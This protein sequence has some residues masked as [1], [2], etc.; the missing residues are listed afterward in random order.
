M[1]L[2]THKGVSDT[3]VVNYLIHKTSFIRNF[4][5][6]IVQMILAEVKDDLYFSRRTKGLY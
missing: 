4:K 3:N 5:I 2:E 1:F 6:K